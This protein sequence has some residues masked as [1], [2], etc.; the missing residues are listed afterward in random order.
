V[1]VDYRLVKKKELQFWEVTFNTEASNISRK[2]GG[3]SKFEKKK[4][5]E[6]IT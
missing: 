4:Q 1:A 2:K 3:Y 5:L 6:G